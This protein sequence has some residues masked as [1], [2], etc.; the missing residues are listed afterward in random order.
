MKNL[1]KFKNGVVIVNTTPHPVTMQDTDGTLVSIPS[2]P[3]YLLNAATQEVQVSDLFVQTVFLDT[4]KGWDLISRIK[5]EF[6]NSEY[7][8]DC[9]LVIVGSILAAQAYKGEVAGLCPVPGYERVAPAEKRMRC[10]K[11]TIFPKQQ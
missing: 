6:L 9:K 8:A 3:L 1:F 11:F 2:D 7:A 5:E 10:D 4:A